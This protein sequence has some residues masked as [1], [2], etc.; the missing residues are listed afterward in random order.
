MLPFILQFSCEV[1]GAATIAPT[2][3]TAPHSLNFNLNIDLNLNLNSPS[4]DFGATRATVQQ[5]STIPQC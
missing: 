2:D 1:I 5:L 3:S 4:A